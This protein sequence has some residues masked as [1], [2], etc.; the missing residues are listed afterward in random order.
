METAPVWVAGEEAMAP[1]IPLVQ[2]RQQAIVSVSEEDWVG[3]T[4]PA[5][6]RKRQN[7]INQRLY[8]RRHQG[9][10]NR[11]KPSESKTKGVGSQI[12][13]DK[14]DDGDSSEANSPDTKLVTKLPQEDGPTQYA[15]SPPPTPNS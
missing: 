9:S 15:T 13:K 5:E 4:D 8:R 12:P 10:S 7:R 11:V 1:M 2:M 6:R 14:L 3:I